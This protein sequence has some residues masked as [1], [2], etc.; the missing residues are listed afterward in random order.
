M[1]NYGILTEEHKHYGDAKYVIFRD[2]KT[3]EMRLDIVQGST[4]LPQF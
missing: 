1:D 4:R 3:G 2:P